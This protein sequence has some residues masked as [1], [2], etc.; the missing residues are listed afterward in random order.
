VLY[1]ADVGHTDP[2]ITIPLNVEVEIDSE[3]NRFEFLE[4]GVI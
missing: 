3:E 2:Q 1:A 4:S